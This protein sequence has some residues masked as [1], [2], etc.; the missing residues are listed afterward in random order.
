MVTVISKFVTILQIVKVAKHLITIFIISLRNFLSQ[1]TLNFIYL[2]V[3]FLVE[4][5][6]Q[7][8][9][10]SLGESQNHWNRVAVKKY[11]IYILGHVSTDCSKTILTLL[12]VPFYFENFT[13]FDVTKESDLAMLVHR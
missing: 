8:F 6:L 5:Y 13:Y 2:L 12:N 1:Q 11:I 3:I 9:L 7:E 4:L 10:V